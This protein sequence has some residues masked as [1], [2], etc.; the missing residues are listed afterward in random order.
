MPDGL[1]K[2]IHRD[3][4]EKTKNSVSKDV[5]FLKHKRNGMNYSFETKWIE[6]QD[7]KSDFRFCEYTCPAQNCM[8]ENSGEQFLLLFLQRGVAV[9]SLPDSGMETE[10]RSK[11]MVFIPSYTRWLVSAQECCYFLCVSFRHLRH[12][13]FRPFLQALEMVADQ[14]TYRFGVLRMCPAVCELVTDLRR[15]L[16]TGSSDWPF[17]PFDMFLAVYVHYP[18]EDL[19]RF[20]YPYLKNLKN[21]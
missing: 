11:Q 5:R 2:L 8:E 6:Y 1:E 21:E 9:V 20:H 15:Q 10:V 18:F 4:G 7:V 16:C 19:A 12:A 14:I 3:T 17:D 13:P